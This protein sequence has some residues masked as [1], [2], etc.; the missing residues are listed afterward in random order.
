MCR[1][2][3]ALLRE[4]ERIEDAYAWHGVLKFTTRWI[5][6]DVLKRRL[7]IGRF[8]VS[9]YP[10]RNQL[11]II[12]TASG[13]L[14][15]INSPLYVYSTWSPPCFC[16]GNGD[17]SKFLTALIESGEYLEAAYLILDSFAHIN[18]EDRVRSLELYRNANV[19]GDQ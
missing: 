3:A 11:Q 9:I 10:R 8:S 13:T 15:D 17:R 1:E 7:L 19:L 5:V 2:V 14:P 6:A 4:D 16:F 12:C 18:L